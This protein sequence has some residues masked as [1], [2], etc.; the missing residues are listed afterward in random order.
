M[1]CM[2]GEHHTGGG[3]QLN[4]GPNVIRDGQFIMKGEERITVLAGRALVGARALCG[5]VLAVMLFA[6]HA[7]VAVRPS[8]AV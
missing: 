1:N 7:T 3:H 4:D 2:R 8:A 5:A 6:A